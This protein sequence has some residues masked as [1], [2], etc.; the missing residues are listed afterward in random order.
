MTTQEQ[1][2]D[3]AMMLLVARS[4]DSGLPWT[5]D[6][7]QTLVARE[8]LLWLQLTDAE[9]KKEQAFLTALWGSRGATR[10]IDVN[11]QWGEWAKSLGTVE[12]P[13][14]AFGVRQTQL[15]PVVRGVHV[16]IQE[17][18]ELAK[19]LDWLWRRGFHPIEY[20]SETLTLLIPAHRIVQETERLVGILIRDW[21]SVPKAPIASSIKINGAYDPV[22]GKATISLSG[23]IAADFQYEVGEQP[24]P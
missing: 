12:I 10:K 21:P 19:L 1:H 22:T 2:R 7:D 20:E 18:P 5:S 17:N 11:P 15:R 16:L 3:L 14:S 4:L 8:R 13:D 9:K 6:E 24:S 23:L